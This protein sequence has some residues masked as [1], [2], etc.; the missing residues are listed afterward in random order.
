MEMKT[1]SFLSIFSYDFRNKVNSFVSPVEGLNF[2][3]HYFDYFLVEIK[4][5]NYFLGF[6]MNCGI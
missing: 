4:V 6:A 2:S 3:I 5:G 1:F